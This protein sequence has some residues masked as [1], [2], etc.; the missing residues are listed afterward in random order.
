MP[1]NFEFYS[2]VEGT[3]RPQHAPNQSVQHARG[4]HVAQARATTP[5]GANTAQMHTSAKVTQRLNSNVGQMSV[6][7]SVPAKN[8][9]GNFR[10][11]LK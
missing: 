7:N 5:V 8:P 10:L 4:G 1:I 6:K 11:H 9:N 3:Q 2:Y